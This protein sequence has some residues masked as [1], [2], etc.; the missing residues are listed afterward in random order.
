MTDYGNAST[1]CTR[2][3]DAEMHKPPIGIKPGW[4]Y[5]T[6]RISELASAIHRYVYDERVGINI[7]LMRMW[8]EE[9]ILQ[10]EI[11][12]KLTGSGEEG[13]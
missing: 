13:E 6:E 3:G 10:L 1:A 11:L 2:A 12:D 7:R 8:A 4:L 9:M 5:A